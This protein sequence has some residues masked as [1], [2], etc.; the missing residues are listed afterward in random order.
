MAGSALSRVID[1]KQQLMESVTSDP[2]AW[3]RADEIIGQLDEIEECCKG[4]F[5]FKRQGPAT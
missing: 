2:D 3:C 1:M 5:N 4:S